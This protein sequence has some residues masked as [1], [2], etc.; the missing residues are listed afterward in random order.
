MAHGVWLTWASGCSSR[1]RAGGAR[2]RRHEARGPGLERPTVVPPGVSVVP[3]DRPAPDPVPE[4][5]DAPLLPRRGRVGEPGGRAARGLH[6][7]PGGA[8]DR[9]RGRRRGGRPDRSARAGRPL[10]RDLQRARPPDAGLRPRLL[11]GPAAASGHASGAGPDRARVVPA[12]IGARDARR[13]RAVLRPDPGF[14]GGPGAARLRPQALAVRAARG[15]GARGARRVLPALAARPV[16]APARGRG[17]RAGELPR[18]RRRAGLPDRALRE[19]DRRA[20][21]EG[22]GARADGPAREGAG[23][24][25]GDGGA[26]AVPQPADG[27]AVGGSR[28][29]RRRAERGGPRDP[30]PLAGRARRDLPRGPVGGARLPR[31]ARRGPREARGRRAGARSTGA[32]LPSRSGSSA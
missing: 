23:R 11:R 16:R 6:P 24:R 8:L 20:A 9:S 15:G 2:R 29:P 19:L 30:A 5:P 26:D 21:R 18:A 10:A 31:A 17:R 25:P 7:P 1:A 13:R 32:I 22:E 12:G 28:G 27:T 14:R 4:L 3:L